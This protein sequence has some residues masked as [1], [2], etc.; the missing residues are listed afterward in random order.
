M[1]DK[2]SNIWEGKSI[3]DADAPDWVGQLMQQAEVEAKQMEEEQAQEGHVRLF[4]LEGQGAGEHLADAAVR[5]R[6]AGEVRPHHHGGREHQPAVRVGLLAP[7]G[8]YRCL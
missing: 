8:I 2:Y 7:G 1:M 5:D 4:K 3:W 6:R